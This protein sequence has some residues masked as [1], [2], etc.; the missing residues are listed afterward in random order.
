MITIEQFL[1]LV[2]FKITGGTEFGWNCFG[3]NARFLDSE[4][5]EYSASIIFDAETQVVYVAEYLGTKNDIPYRW[6]NP[7]F[8]AAYSAY[9][10]KMS[11]DISL[12][13][14]DEPF[15][16]CSENEFGY[17]VTKIKSGA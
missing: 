6:I 4:T 14:N 5:S 1:R 17:Y 8:E 7:D 3:E 10:K 16:D 9:A 12:S 2:N 15:F 13:W 11:V